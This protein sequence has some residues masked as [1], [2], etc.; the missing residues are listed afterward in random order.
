[1]LNGY[2][3]EFVGNGVLICGFCQW[4]A[5]GRIQL[6][7]VSTGLLPP[8]PGG[9]FTWLPPCFCPRLFTPCTSLLQEPERRGS[10]RFIQRRA[11]LIL[12]CRWQTRVSRG[13]MPLRSRPFLF[14]NGETLRQ[15]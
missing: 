15:R 5:P 4:P 10:C 3:L 1:M 12:C 11:G 2:S 7:A 6:E 8:R 9:A 13:C 14:R